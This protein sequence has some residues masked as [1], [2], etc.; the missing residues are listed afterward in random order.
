MHE[1]RYSGAATKKQCKFCS[2]QCGF[3]SQELEH[4]YCDSQAD[5]RRIRCDRL[6]AVV[7]VFGLIVAADKG[8]AGPTETAVQVLVSSPPTSEQLCG[9]DALYVCLKSMGRTDV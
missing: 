4:S 3:P 6:S 1:R 9:V 5:A 2:Q 8:F 7:A